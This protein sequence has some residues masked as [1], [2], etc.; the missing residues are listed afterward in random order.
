MVPAPGENLL[1][2]S[3]HDREFHTRQSNSA[4]SGHYKAINYIISTLLSW[5]SIPNNLLKASP[6]HTIYFE[7]QD[8]GSHILT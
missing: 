8:L 2:T 5:L 3:Y 7:L 6:P 1:A 4:S